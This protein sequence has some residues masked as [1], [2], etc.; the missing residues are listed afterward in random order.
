MCVD[1]HTLIINA[2]IRLQ[3]TSLV[4][5]WKC[6][7]WNRWIYGVHVFTYIPKKIYA[8]VYVH[9]YVYI[10]KYIYI[11]TYIHTYI[12]I[13]IYIH[14]Y[15][16][17]YIYL[18]IYIYIHIIIYIYVTCIQ[19]YYQYLLSCGTIVISPKVKVHLPS[20]RHM[21]KICRILYGYICERQCASEQKSMRTKQVYILKNTFQYG[22]GQTK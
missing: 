15:I 11:Y 1:L 19:I 6:K 5:K 18:Q 8:R 17:I 10:H 2:N 20:K 7:N 3:N 13:Y 22:T 14:T 12:H 21:Q 4:S 16:Y 9:I